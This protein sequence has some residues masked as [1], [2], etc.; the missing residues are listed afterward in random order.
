MNNL[1]WLM[2]KKLNAYHIW[3]AYVSIFVGIIENWIGIAE[4]VSILNEK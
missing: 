1:F 4:V 2:H 3:Y